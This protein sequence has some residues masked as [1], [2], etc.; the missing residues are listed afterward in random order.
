ML[1][2]RDRVG[3]VCILITPSVNKYLVRVSFLNLD[4]I[5]RTWHIEKGR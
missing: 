2:L 3:V 1:C 5:N 4:G